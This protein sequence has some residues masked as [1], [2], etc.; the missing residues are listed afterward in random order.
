METTALQTVPI[1]RV[2]RKASDHRAQIIKVALRDLGDGVGGG[3]GGLWCPDKKR[4]LFS[5][6]CRT[7]HRCLRWCLNSKIAWCRCNGG[8]VGLHDN[9][10]AR[11]GSRLF[12]RS[13]VQ[14]HSIDL[15][16]VLQHSASC[17]D[18]ICDHCSDLPGAQSLLGRTLASPWARAND[19]SK[20][21]IIL[22]IAIFELCSIGHSRLYDATSSDFI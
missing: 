16:I 9:P 8:S 19:T 6:W 14:P 3:R 21:A 10:S 12:H 7:R 18:T 15:V 13:S 11:E 20:R 22:T 17:A 4:P 1:V 5:F 2:Y